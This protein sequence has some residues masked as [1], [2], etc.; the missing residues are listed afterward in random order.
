M[1][2]ATLL[3]LL[4]KYLYIDESYDE[5]VFIVGGVITNIES[6]I[7]K[8]YNKLKKH[9]KRIPLTRKQKLKLMHEFKSFILDRSYQRIKT[10]LFSIIAN[11][12]IGIY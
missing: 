7:T 9:L 6:E 5:N 11:K 8:T 10:I 12:I 3:F 2:Q 4:M 1:M